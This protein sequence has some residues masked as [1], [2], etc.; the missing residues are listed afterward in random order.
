MSLRLSIADWMIGTCREHQFD[1]QAW[2]PALELFHRS[3]GASDNL[4]ALAFVCLDLIVQYQLCQ[5]LPPFSQ[6]DAA[7]V[8]AIQYRVL[9]RNEFDVQSF[10]SLADLL[11]TE[12]GAASALRFY[13]TLAAA[14]SGGS[15]NP[16]ELFSAC[17]QAC[18]LYAGKAAS[19]W[20]LT[21]AALKLEDARTYLQLHRPSFAQLATCLPGKRSIHGRPADA[22]LRFTDGA[23]KRLKIVDRLGGSAPL[24]SLQQ[25]G[26]AIEGRD[27]PRG[28]TT[29][30]LTA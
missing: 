2:V 26:C 7:A 12:R 3:L 8:L 13:V 14:L 20:L 1:E 17:R 6:L 16:R 5:P 21:P 24:S 30:L 27:A 4:Y 19:G 10:E 29:T 18:R 15:D 25:E 23:V 28:S 9:V 22:G 11:A